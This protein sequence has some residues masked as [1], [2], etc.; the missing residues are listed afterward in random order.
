MNINVTLDTTGFRS[1]CEDLAKISGRDFQTVVKAQVALVLKRCISGTPAANKKKLKEKADR[2]KA[3]SYMY[4]KNKDGTK[5]VLNPKRNPTLK[6]FKMQSPK[7]G[8]ERL[9][10]LNDPKRRWSNAIWQKMIGNK[11]F[12]DSI[13]SSRAE[14]LMGARGL[15]KQTWFKMAQKLKIDSQIKAP[16]YV[17]AAK[18]RSKKQYDNQDAYEKSKGKEYVATVVQ[19]Y[20]FL[21]SG[22]YRSMLQNAIK[23]RRLAFNREL[24]KGLFDDIKKRAQRYPGIFVTE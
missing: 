24:K 4:L 11:A 18:Q 17:L 16:K 2:I 1:V 21:T 22:K 23:S 20:R 15:S 5:F 3:F 6:F 12:W 7:D 9:Y 8:V 14:G 13:A 10:A 19:K